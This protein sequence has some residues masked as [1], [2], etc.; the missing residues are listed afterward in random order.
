MTYRAF[1][2]ETRDTLTG[3]YQVATLPR[4]WNEL[5]EKGKLYG[6]ELH[7][8][9]ICVS[10]LQQ[11]NEGYGQVEGDQV[12]MQIAAILMGCCQNGEICI[13]SAGNEFLLLGCRS[14][15]TEP[16]QSFEKTI[17]ERIERYNQTSGKPYRI[18]VHIVSTHV[19]SQIAPDSAAM[20]QQLKK[21]LA[22][23]KKSGHSRAEQM[24]YAAFAKLRQEIYQNPEEDWSVN[25]C[26]RNLEMSASHFQRLYRSMFG[27][28]CMRDVQNSKLCHAKNLLLHTGD[29]LQNIAERCGYDYSHFMRLF[30]KEVGMTPTEYR[31][32]VQFQQVQPE[33]IEKEKAD[34][35]EA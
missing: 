2:S 18:Q 9:M 14:Q 4:F 33:F 31:S 16:E 29:T 17:S 1:L 25:R 20:Y 35:G 6:E 34:D 27:I 24:Y 19:S 11:I 5:R 10:G 12:L 7:I 26:C 28:S 22:E 8:S 15:R 13:R 23:K 3:V 30:K 21:C 32:G